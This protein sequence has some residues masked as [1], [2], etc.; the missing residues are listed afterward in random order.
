MELSVGKTASL[1]SPSK[2]KLT[3]LRPCP[4]PP[5]PRCME[6]SA[7]HSLE[8]LLTPCYIDTH[9][10]SFLKA[11]SARKRPVSP[12]NDQCTPPLFTYHCKP[13]SLKHLLV[14]PW[15]IEWTNR[16][17]GCHYFH[18]NHSLPH[19]TP[20]KESMR[21]NATEATCV[22]FHTKRSQPAETN[23]GVSLFTAMKH[24]ALHTITNPHI[25][26]S[27]HNPKSAFYSRG[28]TFVSKH[29]NFLATFLDF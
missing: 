5:T 27:C 15:L 13:C 11:C 24:G 17:V 18:H 7:G 3:S 21:S 12:S 16:P 6:P 14:D 1:R 20:R 9:S 25:T 22:T 26:L 28:E 4:R 10:P 8:H 2:C 23:K 29:I 19:F